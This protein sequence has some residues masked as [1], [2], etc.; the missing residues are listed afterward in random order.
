LEDLFSVSLKYAVRPS[1]LRVWNNINYG[2]YPKKGDRLSVWL[3]KAKFNELFGSKE[4]LE[5]KTITENNST[6][7]T[8]QPV[9]NKETVL[10]N[11]E[12]K[13]KKETTE[14]KKTDV[15][16][17]NNTEVKKNT[18]TKKSTDTKKKTTTKKTF[19][20]HTVSEGDN[21]TRIA[22]NYGVEVA[23][24]K[25]WNELESDK[26][27]IGQKLKI[28]TDK[29]TSTSSK[30]TKTYT[31][32]SGDNLTAIADANGVS[33]SDIKGWNDLN[34]DVIYEGQVLKLYA[35]KE[36][37]KKDTKKKEKKSKT[38]YYT[39]KKGDNLTQIADKFDV[40]V[41]DI[42]KWNGIKGDVIEIGQKLIVKK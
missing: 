24:I 23:D 12:N 19:Q 40:S 13:E 26:I 6:E 8:E 14:E 37:T 4:V 35:S 41:S 9:E 1:D 10:V 15:K 34:S 17:E 5:E 18:D 36:S 2:L 39:V 32:K 25:D 7:N 30:K 28:Y 33:V 27:T 42:K 31:V 22:D 29:K 3:T 11:K 21:L 20:T 16:K 38:A